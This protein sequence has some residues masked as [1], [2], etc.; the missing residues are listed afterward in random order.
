MDLS[1]SYLCSCIEQEQ[2]FDQSFSVNRIKDFSIRNSESTEIKYYSGNVFLMP[3]FSHYGHS[4]MDMYG[5]YL[6]LKNK[7]PDLKIVFFNESKKGFVY[8]T[9]SIKKVIKDLL[10]INKVSE[11][12]IVDLSSENIVFENLLFIFDINLTFPQDFYSNNG[13]NDYPDYLPFCDCYKGTEPCGQ[14]K[15]FTYNYLVIDELK[16]HF[17]QYRSTINDQKIYVSRKSYNQ[18]WK[19][20]MDSLSQKSNLSDG[21]KTLLRMS[22]IRFYDK[23]QDIED[24]YVKN[25]Y[26]VIYP[27]NHGIIEQIKIFSGA[28]HMAGL[29][30]TWL[31]NVFWADKKTVVHEIKPTNHKYHYDVFGE[32]CVDKYQHLDFTELSHYDIIKSIESLVGG[33]Q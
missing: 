10:D 15:Y 25:G 1:T 4:L 12:E 20:V 17:L 29:S 13:L 8:N 30:G 26:T 5:Q 16:K 33:Q 21:E 28:S 2:Y 7:Y 24:L 18:Y 3:S 6:L 22:Y 27:E 9:A 23:E 14:S 11:D 19:G 31:F 32:Y